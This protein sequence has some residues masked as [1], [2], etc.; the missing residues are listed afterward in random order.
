MK[1]TT[2][3]SLRA[4]LNGA[5]ADQIG[6]QVFLW[7]DREDFTINDLEDEGLL[8]NPAR[9]V[10][11][12]IDSGALDLMDDDEAGHRV[13]QDAVEDWIESSF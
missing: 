1:W 6:E 8:D 7:L 3:Q 12:M 2:L 10:D 4:R 5:S 9:I 11:M 13:A